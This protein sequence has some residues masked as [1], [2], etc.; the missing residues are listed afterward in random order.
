[1]G[2]GNKL[3]VGKFEIHIDLRT[4]LLDFELPTFLSL[5]SSKLIR[6]SP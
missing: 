4:H 6:K 1:M 3:V 5:M 2:I